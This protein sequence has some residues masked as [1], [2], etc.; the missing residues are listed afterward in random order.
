MSIRL[1][2]IYDEAAASDGYRVLVDRVWPR[3][4]SKEQA[5][6]NAWLKEIAPS[7]ELRKWFGH[8][9]EKWQTFK[10]RYFGELD[11]QPDV[12]KGLLE[13]VRRGRV[14]LVYASKE[15]RFNNAVALKQYLNAALAAAKR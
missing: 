3:G 1:R 5:K 11:T 8:T 9:P 15:E 2:R 13:K 4:L 10:A 12:V 6:I 7:T 14:T